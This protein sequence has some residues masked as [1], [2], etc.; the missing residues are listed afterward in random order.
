[1]WPTSAL[2]PTSRQIHPPNIAPAFECRC[3]SVMRLGI[4]VKISRR[5][6]WRRLDDGQAMTYFS[7]SF[8][9]ILLSQS[10][11]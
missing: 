7:L 11:I 2:P 3:P 5:S 4:A 8:I 10:F 1:M 6:S 9:S